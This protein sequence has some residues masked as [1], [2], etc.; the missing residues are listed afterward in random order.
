MRGLSIS[1]GKIQREISA[2]TTFSSVCLPSDRDYRFRTNSNFRIIRLS[3]SIPEVSAPNP[4]TEEDLDKNKFPP[5][6]TVEGVDCL[7]FW[8]PMASGTTKHQELIAEI[9]KLLNLYQS[10]DY[11]SLV[12]TVVQETS[13]R[14]DNPRKNECDVMFTENYSRKNRN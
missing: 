1:N 8:I 5:G 4:V 10:N 9:S 11:E 2:H 3:V 13:S 14:K 6:E 12:R 7:I